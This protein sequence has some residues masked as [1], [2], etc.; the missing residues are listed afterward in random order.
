MNMRK[1]QTPNEHFEAWYVT[2]PVGTAQAKE[3]LLAAYTEGMQFV[4]KD[5]IN[6]MLDYAAATAGLPAELRTAEAIYDIVACDLS[7]HYS[8]ILDEGQ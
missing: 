5:A 6:L 7:E 4:A 1:T 3:L 8:E 2:Y